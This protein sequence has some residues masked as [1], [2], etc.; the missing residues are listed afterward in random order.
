MG[1]DCAGEGSARRIDGAAADALWRK[2][3]WSAQNGSCVE[4]AELPGG[5]VGVRDSKDTSP[6][7]PILTFGKADWDAFISGVR[8]GEFNLGNGG[9]RP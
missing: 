5:L 9:S 6:D 3:T 8:S 1:E 4:V 2:S 7:R